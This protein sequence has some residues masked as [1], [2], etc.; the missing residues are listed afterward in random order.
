M[1]TNR[2]ILYR[3]PL[4]TRRQ[5]SHNTEPTLTKQEFKDDCDPTNI[6]RKYQAT[7]LIEHH[8]Q[9]EPV[10]GD[11]SSMT[12]HE[13][14]QITADAENM[15]QDLPSETRKAFNQDVGQFLDYVQE[16]ENIDQLEKGKLTPSS[17]LTQENGEETPPDSTPPKEE[18]LDPKSD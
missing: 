13:S 8:N 3:T 12:Y 6:L 17:I 15:F 11:Q 16:Q 14:K 18:K 4:N 1:T 2:K 7:G 10:Y 9:Y 5:R